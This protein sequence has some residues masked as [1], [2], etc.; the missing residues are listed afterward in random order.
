LENVPPNPRT[1]RRT[2]WAFVAVNLVITALAVWYWVSEYYGI[3]AYCRQF[4]GGGLCLEP[5][6]VFA[7]EVMASLW[8]VG[9]A[10]L[11][12]I[13]IVG[14]RAARRGR[15]ASRIPHAPVPSRPD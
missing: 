2:T 7:E 11:D 12:T 5:Y 6:H 1:W 8:A 15:E 9:W 10:G 13:L 3:Q 14:T 4:V